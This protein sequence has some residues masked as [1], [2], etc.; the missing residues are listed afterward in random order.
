MPISAIL[1]D[2]AGSQ[3]LGFNF[4]GAGTHE[5]QAACRLFLAGPMPQALK[6]CSIHRV[7]TGLFVR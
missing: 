5:I 2:R 7:V 4:L 1:V 6:Q 3:S